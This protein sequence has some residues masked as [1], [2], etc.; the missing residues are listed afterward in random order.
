MRETPYVKGAIH[1]IG[2]RYYESGAL[3]D[4]IPYENGK[5]HGLE[6]HYFESGVIQKETPYV[7]G[8][9]Q[10]IEKYYEISTF[11]IVRLT[12]YD[13]DRTVASVKV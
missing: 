5:K 6:K 8:V 7:N 2:K 13:K 11:N 3:S 9:R 10:G 4:E 1:G 12:L